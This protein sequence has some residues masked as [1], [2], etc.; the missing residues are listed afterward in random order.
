MNRM[1]H[2]VGYLFFIISEM[3]IVIDDEYKF[4]SLREWEMFYRRHKEAIDCKR[5]QWLNNHI[6]II[7]GDKRYRIFYRHHQLYLKPFKQ[8][9]TAKVKESIQEHQLN[10][11]LEKLNE[12]LESTNYNNGESGG[13]D[14]RDIP[15]RIPN[16]SVIERVQEIKPHQDES[17][18]TQ[19]TKTDSATEYMDSRFR[20][21]SRS[22]R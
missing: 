18:K 16:K 22:R 12:L 15:Q 4:N 9:D 14:T 1:N 5:T 8:I 19:T 20:T 21:I 7:D 6:S 11:I 17:T 3:S 2:V 13:I 10:L